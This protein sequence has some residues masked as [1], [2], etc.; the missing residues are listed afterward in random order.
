MHWGSTER[1]LLVWNRF[2]DN[3]QTNKAINFK[4][5]KYHL[6]ISGKNKQQTFNWNYQENKNSM[7]YNR[8][9]ACI[10]CPFV[11]SISCFSALMFLSILS[12][13]FL[14][15]YLSAWIING[16][17]GAT[18]M[19]LRKL[20]FTIQFK[21]HLVTKHKQNEKMTLISWL[22]YFLFYSILK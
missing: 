5:C 21:F 9:Y 14:Y 16:C 8:A 13:H 22:K 11:I 1:S 10:V 6:C 15:I 4:S 2:Y 18:A 17:R 3:A 12:I 19:L 7:I 20:L